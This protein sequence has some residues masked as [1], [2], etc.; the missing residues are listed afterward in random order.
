M[1]LGTRRVEN[2]YNYG[3]VISKD[4]VKENVKDLILLSS[5]EET[6]IIVVLIHRKE[7][8]R[9]YI[10]YEKLISE[11]VQDKRDL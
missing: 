6:K 1:C 8:S 5:K 7:G 11:V 3:C 4:Q 10:L 2:R 9:V